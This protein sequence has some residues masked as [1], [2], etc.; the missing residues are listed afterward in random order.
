M[1]PMQPM[2][3]VQCDTA[4]I[5]FPVYASPKL[6]GI[7][8]CIDGAVVLSR[9][10]KPIPNEHVQELFGHDFLYGLDGEL[11]VGP[12]NAKDLMQRTTSGVMTRDGEPDVTFHVFDYW[13]E[14]NTPFSRRHELMLRHAEGI[15]AHMPQVKLLEQ[16]LIT[17]NDALMMYESECLAQGYEGVM[18]RKPDS[19][20]KYGRSTLREGYLLKLKR[21]SDSEAVV[22]GYEELMHNGNELQTD[23]MGY[24][25]RSQHKDNLVPM[26][27][28][29][30]LHVRDI[31]SGV[32]FS[33]GTGYT[34]AHRAELWSQRDSLIG[35]LVKYKHFDNSGVKVAP[36]FPVF[37]GFR[38]PLDM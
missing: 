37:L 34:A 27:T 4:N 28:L 18:L 1:K 23:E 12:P 38:S 36:R 30:A 14:P 32:V 15:A 5:P 17:H 16:R 9:K 6:D 20:Y 26:G 8:A 7:R 35:K 29:G 21:F 2:L 31:E 33:I 13:T 3:A 10:L 24:A 19:L 25:K 11:C 22:I